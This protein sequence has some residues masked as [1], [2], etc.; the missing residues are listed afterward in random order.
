MIVS[1]PGSLVAFI[2][3]EARRLGFH[4]VG[5]IPVE[6][7]AR[8]DAYRDWL[9]R[10][11]HGTMEYMASPE[12][13]HA[14]RDP[15]HVAENA[16]T[17]VVV[18]LAYAKSGGVPT[19]DAEGESGNPGHSPP[20]RGFVARYARGKDYHGVM[21]Q[22]LRTLADG[23]SA[24]LG[25][26]VAARPCVD[27]APVL[28]RDLAEAAG[29][30]FMAKNTMVI[31]PGLG[32]YILLGVLLL[33]VALD[34]GPDSAIPF[35]QRHKNRCGSCRACLDAC[36]T[37][38]FPA[39]Y[40]LDARRCVS[41]LTIEHGG[42]IPR[43]LRAGI[44]TMLFG[45]DICQEVCPFNARAPDRHPPDPELAPLDDQ[46][47]AP[48]LIRILSLGSNQRRRYVDG[49]ALRR[50]N[51]EKL[52]RNACVA[53]GNAG[54]HRA[55][56]ALERALDDRSPIVRAHAAWALGALGATE[57]CRQALTRE[58]DP[59]VRAELQAALQSAEH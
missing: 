27:T 20:I 47:G 23:I 2:A 24:H 9:E 6:S 45:C 49:T 29:I 36:P 35:V 43:D 26:P 12:H 48:D 42:A 3:A 44:G 59:D 34:S 22:R 4:R 5:V 8:Y 46:R 54:D 41:Y 15:R 30:G 1:T 39:P 25:R 51:R 11:M 50:A 52:L 32:S 19:R 55:I 57:P 21:K 31:A 56:P 38:A 58:T 37:D 18:A 40:V 7:P 10:D 53:L 28:E 33:D 13:V 14:R 16:R 17:M